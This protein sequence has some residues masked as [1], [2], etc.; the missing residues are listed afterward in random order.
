MSMDK[1]APLGITMGEATNDGF[2]L[3]VD[4]IGQFQFSHDRP[5]TF[6]MAF[7]YE[8]SSL[9]EAE[10]VEQAGVFERI[11][12]FLAEAYRLPL[13][14]VVVVVGAKEYRGA[15]ENTGPAI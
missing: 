11:A 8:E 7:Y 9:S 1:N 10:I 5:S 13:G 14:K 6:G 12:R 15:A 4:G 2:W 3:T